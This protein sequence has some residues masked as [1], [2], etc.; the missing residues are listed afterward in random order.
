MYQPVLGFVEF[1]SSSNYGTLDAGLGSAA[2]VLAEPSL[3]RLT[4]LR[5]GCG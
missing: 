3:R 5:R 1:R 2:A 4:S